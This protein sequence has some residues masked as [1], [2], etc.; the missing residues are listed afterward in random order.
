MKLSSA[1]ASPAS[2]SA[3]PAAAAAWICRRFAGLRAWLFL[4]AGLLVLSGRAAEPAGEKPGQRLLYVAVPGIRDYLEYGGHGLL[5][6]DIEDGHKFLRR[7]KTAGLSAAG[8]PLN[9]KGICAS[10]AGDRI[11]ISTLETLTCLR[12]STDEL[13]WERR[14]EGGCDRMSIT[15]DGKVIYLPSLE[16]AHWHVIDAASGEV[17]AKITPDSGA[18]NTVVGLDGKWVYLAGLKSPLVTVADTATHAAARTIGPFFS[19][20]RPLTVDGRQTR[21]FACVNG[22]LGFEVADI[23]SGKVLHRVKVEGFKTGIP[24]RHGCPSHGIGLT[25]DEREIWLCDAA[26]QR[27]HVFDATLSPPRQRE[28]IATRDQPGWI[29]FS[30]DGRFAYP[31]TGEVIEAATKQIIATLSDETGAPVHSEK[32]LEVQFAGGKPIRNGDQFGVGRVAGPALESGPVASDAQP[33]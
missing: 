22:L 10:A 19:A 28:S 27:M 30:L 15:P 3:A 4:A 2:F 8:K 13:L 33:Q 24:K 11:Y 18:H 25:P 1:H 26:N 5:V 9:V 7:I 23:A 21:L 6:F 29:T 17:L 16:K 31:S 20:V 14:Y 32:L 12:L